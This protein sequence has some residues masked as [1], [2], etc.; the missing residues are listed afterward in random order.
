MCGML[1]TCS[2]RSSVRTT[3]KS[4]RTKDDARSWIVDDSNPICSE[5]ASN[6]INTHACAHT[7]IH[8]HVTHPHITRTRTHFCAVSSSTCD[9]LYAC[10]QD[11]GRF[12]I[13]DFNFECVTPTRSVAVCCSLLQCVTVCCSVRHGEIETNMQRVAWERSHV[14]K[15]VLSRVQL[16]LL[17]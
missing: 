1:G 3:T 5:T 6:P 10:K 14:N 2:S 17:R 13:L 9:F 15:R 8:E 7:R 12:T 16:I 11:S 4:I